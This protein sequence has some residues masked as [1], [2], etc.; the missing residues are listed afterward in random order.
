[1]PYKDYA[2]HT[3][4]YELVNIKKSVHDASRPKCPRCRTE[5]E[6]VFGTMHFEFKGSGWDHKIGIKGR[7]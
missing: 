7:K 2:C 3:C 4:G 6:Q 5:M 1:V